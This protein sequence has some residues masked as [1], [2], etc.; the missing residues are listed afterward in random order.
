MEPNGC[1][2]EQYGL[3]DGYV[4][5]TALKMDTLEE[6]HGY[7]I[8]LSIIRSL[9]EE[10][11]TIKSPGCAF[12]CEADTI[13]ALRDAKSLGAD[14]YNAFCK[15]RKLGGDRFQIALCTYTITCESAGRGWRRC[16]FACGS[17]FVII[18][19]NTISQPG[20]TMLWLCNMAAIQL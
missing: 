15:L 4:S 14:Q 19:M 16:A 7:A 10:S 20:T 3:V 12:G 11:K 9:C 5:E 17:H 18:S 8:S 13:G 1:S 6:D 2:T